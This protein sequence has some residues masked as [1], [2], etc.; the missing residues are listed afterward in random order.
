MGI[1]DTASQYMNASGVLGLRRV[2]KADLYRIAK[3]TGATVITTMA[4]P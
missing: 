1:D 4:T 2:D 3:L